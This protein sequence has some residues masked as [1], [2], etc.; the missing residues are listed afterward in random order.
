[1]FLPDK[2]GQ[3]VIDIRYFSFLIALDEHG[4]LKLAIL[5]C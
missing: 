1:M 3:V 4:N 2:K 5:Y